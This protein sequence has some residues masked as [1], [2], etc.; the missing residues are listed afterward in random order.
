MV[1][2]GFLPFA[3]GCNCGIWTNDFWRL[4][5]FDESFAAGED[6]D[7]SWR[8]QLAGR[9]LAFGVGAVVDRR[10][11]VCAMGAAR[12]HYR[13]GQANALL[14]R[15]YRSAGMRRPPVRTV[16]GDWGLIL[17]GMVPRGGAPRDK[18]ARRAGLHLGQL[19]GSMRNRVIFP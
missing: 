2:H 6:I 8:A 15:R 19:V 13:Y 16:A 12:Q 9:E 14:Y 4:G 1:A 17:R 5:G 11:R 18:W 7:L 10:D 3:S